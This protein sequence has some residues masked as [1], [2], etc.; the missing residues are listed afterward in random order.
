MSEFKNAHRF[1]EL[2]FREAKD[3]LPFK[4]YDEFIQ[5]YRI[6]H[7]LWENYR[8]KVIHDDTLMFL[9][10]AFEHVSRDD[11]AAAMK[12]LAANT[13]P[14]KVPKSQAYFDALSGQ[15]EKFSFMD[16]VEV[17][18]ETGKD[19]GKVAAAGLGIWAAKVLAGAALVY[20]AKQALAAK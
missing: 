2:Y 3:K 8:E 15:V 18:K 14:G 4:T 20:V 16:A 10:K 6:D 17:A 7:F 19:M 11:G 1:L 12:S 13:V 9:D 5:H